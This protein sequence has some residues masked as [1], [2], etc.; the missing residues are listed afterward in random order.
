MAHVHG[1][2]FL[3]YILSAGLKKLPII[4][5][6]ISPKDDAAIEELVIALNQF[7]GQQLLVLG[8][9]IIDLNNTQ[10]PQ[11][12][13]IASILNAPGLEDMIPHF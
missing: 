7:P 10:W 12:I 5:I 1:P 9:L 13:A 11:D 8:N 3:S 4:G 6:Y 2:N